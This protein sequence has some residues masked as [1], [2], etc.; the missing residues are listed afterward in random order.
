MDSLPAALEMEAVMQ[1]N[2]IKNRDWFLW[3]ARIWTL[4]AIFFVG[5]ELITPHAGDQAVAWEDGVLLAAILLAVGGLIL[6]WR[7][8]RR[9]GL[10][11]VSGYLLHLAAWP[12][13]RGGWAPT[14]GLLGLFVGAPG[15]LLW[16]LST[17]KN[18]A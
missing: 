8:P 16:W 4:P 1:K 3:A 5:A 13:L 15:L 11:A 7:W 6:A 10:L 17:D 12:I 2:W 9:G 18:R 14:W